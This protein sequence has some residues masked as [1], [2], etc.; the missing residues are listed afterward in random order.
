[1]READ[2]V[3]AHPVPVNYSDSFKQIKI[4]FLQL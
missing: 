1:L 3:V 2:W 4:V